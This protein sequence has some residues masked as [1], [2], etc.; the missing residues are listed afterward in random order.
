MTLGHY[1]DFV[2][3]V[4]AVLCLTLL[5]VSIALKGPLHCIVAWF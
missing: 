5:R 4:F 3:S 1:V 2:Y